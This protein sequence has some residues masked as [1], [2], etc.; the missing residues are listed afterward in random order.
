MIMPFKI[1]LEQAVKIYEFLKQSGMKF[2]GWSPEQ[3]R[4]AVSAGRQSEEFITVVKPNKEQ[5]K[6]LFEMGFI[7]EYPDNDMAFIVQKH[8]LWLKDQYETATVEEQMEIDLQWIQAGGWLSE[9]KMDRLVNAGKIE[10]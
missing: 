6:V 8:G 1:N 7:G 5:Q 9:E 4:V 2:Y 10:K 3:H